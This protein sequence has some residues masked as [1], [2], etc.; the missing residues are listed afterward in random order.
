M[1]NCWVE[2][3]RLAVLGINSECHVAA[4]STRYYIIAFCGNKKNRLDRFWAVWK[5]GVWLSS[6][7]QKT[8]GF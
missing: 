8:L 3:P 1:A 6:K 7:E 5:D 2:V 4:Y